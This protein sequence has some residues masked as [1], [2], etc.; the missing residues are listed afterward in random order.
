MKVYVRHILA[1]LATVFGSQASIATKAAAQDSAESQAWAAAQSA[2]TK[3]AYEVYLSSFPI[4]SHSREA[5]TK[6]VQLSSDRGLARNLEEFSD[7]DVFSIQSQ[8]TGGGV[9]S[10]Y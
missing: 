3:Q 7:G 9:S 10:L 8:S 1:L 2:G 5:F 4:G 6:I